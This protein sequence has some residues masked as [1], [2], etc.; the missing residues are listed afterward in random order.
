M[1]RA[2]RMHES[3]AQRPVIGHHG[4]DPMT[5]LGVHRVEVVH[6]NQ[7]SH[8]VQIIPNCPTCP[9][10]D[11]TYLLLLNVDLGELDTG[12]LVLKLGKVRADELARATPG[13]PVVDNDGLGTR[14]LDVSIDLGG[15]GEGREDNPVVF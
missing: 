15:M 3:T 13:C 9:S 4:A 2:A 10:C 12:V 5:S 6:S 1:S 14:D 8:N 7:V 11:N